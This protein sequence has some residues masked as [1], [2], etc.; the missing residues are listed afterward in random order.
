MTDCFFVF[1]RLL[2]GELT[3]DQTF[4]FSQS[5]M[6]EALAESGYG[7]HLERLNTPYSPQ[8]MGEPLPLSLICG[9]FFFFLPA[10]NPET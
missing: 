5:A 10:N 9:L 2:E 7:A 6:S 1:F 4:L 3:V 8:L